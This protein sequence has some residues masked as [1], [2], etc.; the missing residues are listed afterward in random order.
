MGFLGTFHQGKLKGFSLIEVMIVAVVISVVMVGV[1]RLNGSL[2]A[3][4]G[5]ESVAIVGSNQNVAE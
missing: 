5:Q 2:L 4:K 1:I 3:G